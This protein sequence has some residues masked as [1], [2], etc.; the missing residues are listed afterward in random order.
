MNNQQH[1]TKQ[2]K[3]NTVC[4]QRFCEEKVKSGQH[5]DAGG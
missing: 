4:A 3:A 2:K 5:H 1:F